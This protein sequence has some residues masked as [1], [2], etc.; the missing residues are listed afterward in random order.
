MMMEGDSRV[1]PSNYSRIDPWLISRDTGAEIDFMGRAFGA[2]ERPGS[3]MLDADGKIVHVEVELADSIVM[4]FDTQPGWPDLPAHLRVYVEDAEATVDN[5]VATGARVVTR[6]RR[7]WPS[8]SVSRACAIPRATCGGST[9]VWKNSILRRSL[10]GLPN[11][12]F[13]RTW[14]TSRNP[15]ATS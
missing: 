15:W 11:P 8:G 14:L 5:A 9:S 7:C 3:R 12:L 6:R 2:R 13:S 1:V 10:G 4:M